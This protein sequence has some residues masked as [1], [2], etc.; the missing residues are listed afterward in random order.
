MNLLMRRS[1][2]ILTAF[3]LFFAVWYFNLGVRPFQA[4]IG[5]SQTA[6]YLINYMVAGLIP[7]AA[8]WLL[9]RP[10][11]IIPSLGLAHGIGVGARFGLLAT[12]P[13]L[14]G[15]ACIGA[16]DREISADHLLTRVVIAG[17]FEE[18]I[19]RGFV[20]GQLFR[21]ARWGFLPAALLTAAAFGSLHLYQGHDPL[22]ALAAFAVTGA[23]SLF[24]SWI[25]VEWQ[26]N[27]WCAVWLHALMNLPWIL[28]SVSASGAVGGIAANVLRFGTLAIA[29]GLTIAYK[30]Q[31]GLPYF[32]NFKSLIVNYA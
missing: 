21:Y 32:I 7:A 8:L 11:M 19:F 23:G 17:F 16:F 26:Y 24:F 6:H 14:I 29:V 28:F 30:K 12:L 15:Y 31:R 4:I 2:I 18:L 27:L 1:I 3:V 5:A 10:Q 20:F 22:S 25:Y 13:M 9:H